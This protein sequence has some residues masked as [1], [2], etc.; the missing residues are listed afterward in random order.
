MRRT[1]SL[2]VLA[3]LLLGACSGRPEQPTGTAPSSSA[4]QAAPGPGT[5]AGRAARIVRTMHVGGRTWDLTVDSPAVGRQLQV[6]LLLPA[7]FA[8]EPARRWP[9]LYLLHGCCDS[10]LSWTRSTDVERRTRALDALVVMPDGGA[11]GFYSDWRTGPAWETFHL[12]EL[13]ALLGAAYRAGTPRVVAGVSMG[14][15]GALGYAARHPGMFTVAASFSGIVHTRLAPEES[16]GYLDLV[17][18]EGGDPPALWGDP[19]AD[20]AVWQAHNPYD[21]APKLRGTRL[22]VSAGNGQPGPLD[23]AGTVPDGTEAALHAENAAFARRLADLHLDA[24]VDLYGAGT[25][26]WVYWQRELARAWP[27]ITAGLA[28]R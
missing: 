24:R 28:P 3:A 17:R 19:G 2:L 8:A 1:T 16:Q 6:R 15:L 11:V 4:V 9:V 5:P 18:S 7:R 23:P 27:L 14:G 12:T 26:S 10:Y 21:L 22:F 25:H 20:A 13:P